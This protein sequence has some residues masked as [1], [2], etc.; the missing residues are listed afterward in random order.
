MS[1]NSA[2][3]GPGVVFESPVRKYGGI[4]KNQSQGRVAAVVDVKD[5]GRVFQWKK[6]NAETISHWIAW[7]LIEK[8]DV[9]QEGGEFILRVSTRWRTYQF[10]LDNSETLQEWKR[11]FAD[12]QQ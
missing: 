12:K 1:I 9:R 2:P 4:A 8:A 3:R 11:V 10:W 7:N 5:I 6:L